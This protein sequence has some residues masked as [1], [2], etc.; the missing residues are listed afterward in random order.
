MGR[1]LLI[2]SVVEGILIVVLG[3][4]LAS[5]GTQFDETRI[6]L[7]ALT[8]KIDSLQEDV[9]MLADERAALQG[10]VEE[11]LGTIEQLK[12]QLDRAQQG[13]QAGP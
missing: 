1:R 3:V 13:G 10:Q 7:R 5:V 11:Q 9:E 6:E 2:A 8:V 12:V 4:A